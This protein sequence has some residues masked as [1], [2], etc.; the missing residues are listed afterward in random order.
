MSEGER[1][2]RRRER[3]RRVLKARRAGGTEE[4]SRLE[5]VEVGVSGEF[6]TRVRGRK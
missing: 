6:R 5:Q 1:K 4:A 3:K 2:R